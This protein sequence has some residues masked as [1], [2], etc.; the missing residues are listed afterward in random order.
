MSEIRLL[1]EVARW[2]TRKVR[3][4]AGA[5]DQLEGV[6]PSF[7]LSD[8]HDGP[9]EPA[10]PFLRSVIRL[11]IRKAERRIPVGIVSN[12]YKLVQHTEVGD[13]CVSGIEKAGVDISKVRCEL[14]LTELDE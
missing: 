2:H 6:I 13:R 10:N 5:W 14:G 9:E 12:N 11:P 7:E 3:Y 8:F 4:L 1:N